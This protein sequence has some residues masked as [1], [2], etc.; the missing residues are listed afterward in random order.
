LFQNSR[1]ALARG[2]QALGLG[3]LHVAPLGIGR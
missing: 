2:S 1:S 3:V